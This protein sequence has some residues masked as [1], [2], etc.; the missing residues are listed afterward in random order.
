M[1]RED[2]KAMR[3]WDLFQNAFDKMDEEER[4]HPLKI[5]K[6]RYKPKIPP[7]YRTVMDVVVAMRGYRDQASLH[8]TIPA[9]QFLLDNGW[10]IRPCESC[11]RGAFSHESYKV[12]L[13][14][15]CLNFRDELIRKRFAT[16]LKRRTLKAS[17]LVSPDISEYVEVDKISSGC[18]V[19]PVSVEGS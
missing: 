9:L 2:K 6:S 1:T 4:R 17:R 18:L 5:P 13:C 16:T 14:A 15:T 3:V 12:I 19:P 7:Q 8:E 10:K 11:K